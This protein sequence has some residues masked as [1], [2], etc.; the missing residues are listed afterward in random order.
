[1]PSAN[2]TTLGRI[3]TDDEQSLVDSVVHA[4]KSGYRLIDCA[5]AYGVEPAIGKAVRECGIPRSEI[6]VMTKFWVNFNDDPETAL[7]LSLQ[8]LDLDY[9]DLFLMHY[10]CSMTRDMKP[11]P[12]DSPTTFVDTWKKMERLVGPTCRSIGVC[13]MTEKT[14]GA[15]LSE[16]SIVPAVNQIELHAFNPNMKLVPFCE[17]KGIHVIS[18]R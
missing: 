12:I 10:P 6:L 18:W 13:N 11:I 5:M 15:L 4:L 14:L 16:A 17:S 3:G 7:Q 8:S 9:V 1:M 2:R